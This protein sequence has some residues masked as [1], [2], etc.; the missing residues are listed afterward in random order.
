MIIRACWFPKRGGDSF[1]LRRESQFLVRPYL[2]GAALESD[3]GSPPNREHLEQRQ[4]HQQLAPQKMASAIDEKGSFP[5]ARDDVE[6]PA[7]KEVRQN[8]ARCACHV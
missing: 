2:V 3:F 4:T 7:V 8:E 5:P 1:S 6:S